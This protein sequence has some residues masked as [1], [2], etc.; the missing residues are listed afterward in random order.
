[1]LYNSLKIIH[2]LSASLLLTS[3]G[4]SFWQ[5]R[6][7]LNDSGN[8]QR[9]ESIQTQ[10]W[11]VIIPFAL[12]QL[13]TGF[14]MMSL[15]HEN[16]SQ[17]WISGSVIGFITA[18]ASWLTFI[19]FLLSGSSRKLQTSSLIFCSFGLLVMIFFMANKIT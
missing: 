2:I 9:I 12:A 10:T 15:Q 13:I 6:M 14:T 4:Y 8:T 17:I 16:M 7:A 18:L 3:M 19:Y 5:W 11:L 1:M